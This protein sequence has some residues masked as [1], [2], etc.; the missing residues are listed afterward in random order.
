[1]NRISV[2]LAFAAASLPFST[3]A[4]EAT[5][6]PSAES[7][8]KVVLE[9][10]DQALIQK[11]PKLAFERFVSPA[12]VE[13]K[14]DV[15][16]GTRDAVATFLEGLIAQLPAARWEVLRTVAEPELVAL[17]ARFVPAPGAPAYAIVDI[18][19]V[20]NCRIVEHWDVVAPPRPQSPASRAEGSAGDT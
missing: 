6:S 2:L 9:F 18:F 10:Y 8:R 15:A 20:E 17:H 7:S 13:H 5:C 1:M 14:A 16:G 12:F 3:S 19:R 4:R 11:K